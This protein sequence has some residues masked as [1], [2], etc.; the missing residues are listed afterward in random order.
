MRNKRIL[1]QDEM[2]EAA[3]NRSDNYNDL[4]AEQQWEEDKQLGILDWNGEED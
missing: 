2:K 1:T 3:K 4:S